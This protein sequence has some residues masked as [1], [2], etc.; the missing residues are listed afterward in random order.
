MRRDE[1]LQH[2]QA[3]TEVRRDRRLDDRAVRL[4]HQATHTGQLTNLNCRSTRARI[5][6]HVDRVERFLLRLITVA[7]DHGFRS[8]LL[9]HRLADRFRRCRP[10]VDHVVVALLRGDETRHVL[11]VVFLHLL[12]CIADDLFFL[13]RH[14]HV[15]DANRNTGA[16]SQTEPHLHQLVGEDHRFAQT[17]LAE[18]RV[19]QARNFLL[20]QRT[21]QHRE[22]QSWRQD[23]RQ[24]GTANGGCVQRDLRHEL[25]CA[26]ALVRVVNVFRNPD[27]HPRRQLDFLVFVRANRFRHAG[28]RHAFALAIHRFTRCVVKTQHDIL[29]RHDRRIAVGRE[30]D[31]VRRQH[32]RARFHLRFQRQ[33]H[34]NG[35]LVT[36]EVGVE[37]RANERMQLDRLAFDQHRLES[38]NAETVKRR[39]TVQHDRMFTNDF[40]ENV[41]H[42]GC[43]VLDFLL[44][45]LDGGSNTH[46]FQLVEDERLEQFERH[47]LRQTA[48]MQ[49]ERRTHHDHR[50]ARIVNALT[51]QV[52]T[53]TTALTLDHVSERLQRTLVRAG[54]CLTATTIVEQRI[55]GFLQHP[56]FVADDDL[57]RLQFEQTFQPVV[58]VDHAAIQVVQVRR[59]ETA[60]VERHERTQFRRQHRQHFQHHPVRLDARTLECLEHFQ[61]LR[62]LLDLRFRTR[63][64]EFGAQHFD[65]F[66]DVDCA[67]QFTHAFRAHLGTEFVAV[68]F[69]LVVVILFRHDLPRFQRR[70]ARFDH[71]V[72]FEIQHAFDVAQRH[73]EHHAQTRRQRLQ[74][75]DVR[76]RRGQFNVAHPFATH[77]G[78]R[79]FDAALFADHATVLQALVLAAQ[80]LVV[81]DRAKNLGAEQTIAF[82][83]EGPVVDGFRLL[84]FA[85]GPRADLVRRGQTDLDRV[86]YFRLLDLLE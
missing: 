13:R 80:A 75:P 56:L 31:V 51:E 3:F 35:H 21:V 55:D 46:H 26:F 50:T 14:E 62:V 77:L 64:L 68:F 33:R 47:Q 24:D 39:R 65:L 69:N 40:F 76:N 25:R 41:P 63:V 74:E 34:V 19:D 73:V 72:R 58:T 9:H 53:E 79:H 45:G 17:A 61:A 8:Q 44:R 59:S 78:E 48:L 12:G 82:R 71:H 10:D 70:H 20:L 2:V 29:R 54:H 66:V 52:L 84:H 6:H 18:C 30:Q 11:T 38:L 83:L 27:I 32:Q 15:V 23:L 16:R 22:R 37:R 86:E 5:G 7:V 4:R 1:V 28:E 60:T 81:L 67:Q 43:L 42:H 36:V 57:R 49:L 85:E